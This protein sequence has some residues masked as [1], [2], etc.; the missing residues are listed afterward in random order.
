VGVRGQIGTDHVT[1]GHEA[2][3]AACGQGDFTALQPQQLCQRCLGYQAAGF[4][5]GEHWGLIDVEPHIQPNTDQRGADQ[6]RQTPAPLHERGAVLTDGVV[7]TQE[8]QAG[9]YE[10]GA[11]TG[12]GECAI[13]AAFGSGRIFGA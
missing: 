9:Q 11:G 7:H 4:L 2:E 12:H 5:L 6:E 1:E 10:P 3:D 13:A 8:C